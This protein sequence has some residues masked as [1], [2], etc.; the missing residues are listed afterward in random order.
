MQ[1]SRASDET[2]NQCI[3]VAHAKFLDLF[4]RNRLYVNITLGLI[5]RVPTAGSNI[6]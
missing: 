6:N 1:L 5:T 2:P 4:E 3:P